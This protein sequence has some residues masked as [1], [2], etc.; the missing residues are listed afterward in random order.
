MTPPFQPREQRISAS[1]LKALTDCSLAFYYD[2]ILRLPSRIWGRTII[3]SLLHSIFECLRNPRHRH[4]YDTLIGDRKTVDYT[5]SAAVSRLVRM[6]IEKHT[7]TPDLIVDL[8]D[9]LYVGLV[10]LDFHWEGADRDAATGK[11]L[12]YGPEHAFQIVLDDGTVIKGFID[13]MAVVGGVMR[14]RDFKSARNKP[15]AAEVPD[16]VQAIIYQAYIWKTFQ[17]PAEVTFVYLRHPPTPR[18]KTRHLQVVQPAS[19][20]HLEGLSSY[21]CA[22]YKRINAFTFEDAMLS[23]HQDEGFCFRVCTHYAPHPYWTIHPA[24][25]PTGSATEPLSSH[26]SLDIAKK[27]AHDGGLAVVE[28]AFKGC[29]A[30]WRG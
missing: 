29:A 4:H 27:I 28:R 8:N 2:K 22:V 25:D 7:I 11:A 6:W 10:L 18:A 17:L 16:N 14:V 23:P 1:A 20:T 19:A 21:V 24:A 5:R 15:T 30:R 9:M 3:G 13:D 26:L 12:V